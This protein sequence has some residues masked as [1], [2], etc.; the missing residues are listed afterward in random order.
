MFCGDEETKFDNDMRVNQWVKIGE[1]VKS[2]G[3]FKSGLYG[4]YA[5][6]EYIETDGCRKYKE[7]LICTWTESIQLK[8]QDQV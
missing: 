1:V 8:C 4:K 7:I 2:A 6:M 3:M 5:V